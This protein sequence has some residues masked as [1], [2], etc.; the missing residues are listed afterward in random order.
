MEK[1]QVTI[2]DPLTSL[3]VTIVPVIKT[4]VYSW[5]NRGGPAVYCLVKPLYILVSTVKSPLKAFNMDGV[6]TPISTLRT[7]FPELQSSLDKLS[8]E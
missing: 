5:Q 8:A 4:Q 6:E 3:G 1:E 2:G 7:L